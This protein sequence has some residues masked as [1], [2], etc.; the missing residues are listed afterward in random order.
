[1]SLYLKLFRLSFIGF[2]VMSIAL[3]AIIGAAYLFYSPQLPAVESLRDVQ[4]QTPLKVFSQEGKLIAI[5]G[6]QRTERA[7]G[8][9]DYHDGRQKL[10]FNA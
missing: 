7:R 2:L 10:L 3:I 5:Y 9:H 8:Q 6:N 1:M 4:L